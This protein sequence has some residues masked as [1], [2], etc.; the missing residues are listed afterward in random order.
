MIHI[1]YSPQGGGL[2]SFHT[3]TLVLVESGVQEAVP[4]R[5]AVQQVHFQAGFGALFSSPELSSSSF[6]NLPTQTTAQLATGAGRAEVD[7]L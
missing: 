6:E 1:P 2:S 7:S 4:I 3:L 5:V